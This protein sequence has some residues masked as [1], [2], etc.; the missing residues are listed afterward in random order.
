MAKKKSVLVAA[1]VTVAVSLL[2]F[3]GVPAPVVNLI[4]SIGNTV[5]TA[6]QQTEEV[7][8]QKE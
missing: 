1:A 7:P 5:S 6:I 4:A 3:F 8:D 2:S